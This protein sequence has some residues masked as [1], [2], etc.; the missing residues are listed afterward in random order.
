[1]S[2]TTPGQPQGYPYCFV[3]KLREDII[4]EVVAINQ[5]S[6]ILSK[7]CIPEVNKVICGIREDEERHFGL[8]LNLVRKYDPEQEKQYIRT[9]ESLK[10][11]CPQSF[12]VT[13]GPTDELIL[14][15]IRE[16]VKGEC[17]AI[18]LYDQDIIEIPY[19]DARETLKTV[20]YEEKHHIE[21]LVQILLNFDDGNYFPNK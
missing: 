16:A 3:N 19:K 18:I 14:N 13:K 20:A 10:F 4:A 9:I 6:E 8:F 21:E 17:E 7:C 15:Y 11:K 1:M 12:D 5:Y 2:Y